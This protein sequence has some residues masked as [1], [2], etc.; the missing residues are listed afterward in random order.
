MGDATF[1]DDFFLNFSFVWKGPFCLCTTN[2]TI[3]VFL[4]TREDSLRWQHCFVMVVYIMY[5][6]HVSWASS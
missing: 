6:Q 3:I 5:N 4:S 1:Y 2:T